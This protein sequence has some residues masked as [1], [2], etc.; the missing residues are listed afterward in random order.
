METHFENMDPTHS[1]IARERVVAELKSLVRDSEELLKATASDVSEK[2]KEA[3]VRLTG[4]LDRAKVTCNDVQTQ[5]IERA[6]V[7]A[8]KADEMIRTHPYESLGVSF[9][10]GLLI[11]V[12]VSRK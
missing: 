7:A 9:G 1:T 6:R 2:A 4:A 10:I 11:G 12:L 5:T 8:Q 3:R